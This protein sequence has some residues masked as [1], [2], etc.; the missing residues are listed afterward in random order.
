MT[1][2][3]LDQ[4]IELTAEDGELFAKLSRARAMM[5]KVCEICDLDV[6][7]AMNLFSNMLVMLAINECATR[8]QVVA[9]VGMMYDERLKADAEDETLN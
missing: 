7:E 9:S 8:E 2:K 1:I 4:A 6:G 5:L 3:T